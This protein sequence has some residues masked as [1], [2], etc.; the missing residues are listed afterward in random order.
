MCLTDERTVAST[1][2]NHGPF[3]VRER[4][5]WK[6]ESERVWG[7]ESQERERERRGDQRLLLSSPEVA[8][9][10]V[11]CRCRGSKVL[12]EVLPAAAKAVEGLCLAEDGEVRRGHAGTSLCSSVHKLAPKHRQITVNPLWSLPPTSLSLSLFA[13]Q[14]TTTSLHFLSATTLNALFCFLLTLW[15]SKFIVDFSSS[16]SLTFFLDSLRIVGQS[17]PSSRKSGNPSVV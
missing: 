16:C 17:A 5:R 9:C 11:C 15:P 6:R 1:Q 14:K 2:K 13:Q 4:L 8:W 3:V 7:G 12:L 10:E